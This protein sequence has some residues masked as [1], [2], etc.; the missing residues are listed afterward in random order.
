MKSIGEGRQ[1]MAASSPSDHEI[2]VRKYGNRRLYRTDESRYVTLDDL[3]QLVAD[4][5]GFRVAD[6]KS[7]Q[8]L[9]SIV[10]AQVI[11]EQVRKGDASLYP[12]QV[13][14][15]IIRMRGD[16]LIDFVEDHLPRLM[17][18]HIQSS[19]TT[20]EL[21]DRSVSESVSADEAALVLR[22][23]AMRTQLDQI[24]DTLALQGVK[25]GA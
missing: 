25:A 10:L 20:R 11:L 12:P 5:V 15:Q 21:L 4:D 17:D 6:A 3:A 8:D 24:L 14:R 2:V 18:L 7:G 9:T 1:V 23:K 19:H 16:H 22:L 13:L